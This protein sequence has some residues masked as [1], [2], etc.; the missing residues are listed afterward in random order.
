[1]PDP[2]D[3]EESGR[4]ETNAESDE[5]VPLSDLRDDIAGV[6]GDEEKPGV[7]RTD[8]EAP[9]TEKRSATPDE[10]DLESEADR[11]SDEGR[12]KIPLSELKDDLSNREE[13][14]EEDLF[15]R[16][17]VDDV[18]AEAVW[19][20]LLMGEGDTTEAFEPTALE[21]IDGRDFQVV[22]TTLCHRCE[23]FGDPPT[24]HC[25][26]EGTTIHETV[27]MDH[28]RVSDCPMVK[29][30]GGPNTEAEPSPGSLED[31]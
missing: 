19:A 15:H 2:E 29:T 22:P 11:G 12:E 23:F 30:E 9:P 24:L 17:A 16:E 6:S 20:D 21:E 28:Y 1:M 4:N 8:A 26:H 10:S 5:D 31:E 3:E 7:D 14:S 25:T 13:T 27:D 18:E